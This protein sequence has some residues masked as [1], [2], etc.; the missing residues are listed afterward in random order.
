MLKMDIA[1]IIQKYVAATCWIH[2]SCHNPPIMSYH[3]YGLPHFTPVALR[4]QHD[5][6]LGFGI[7]NQ[8]KVKN[9]L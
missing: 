2:V 4:F 8:E 7:Y 3:L 5:S 6:V 1:Y 9:I